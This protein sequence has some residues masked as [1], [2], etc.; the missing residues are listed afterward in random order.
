MPCFNRNICKFHKRARNKEFWELRDQ[1]GNTI[2]EHAVEEVA[3]G[4]GHKGS[5]KTDK[6]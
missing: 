6:Q 4:Q 3:V 5:G 1:R 2:R